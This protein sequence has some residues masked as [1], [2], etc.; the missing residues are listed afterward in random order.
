MVS[1]ATF[2]ERGIDKTYCRCMFQ[3]TCV[4]TSQKYDEPCSGQRKLNPF[5]NKPWFLRVCSASLFENTVGKGEIARYERFL[6]F[7]VFYARSTNFL[8]FFSNL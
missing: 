5:P 4:V 6:L 7:P 8:P 3:H 1:Q 2:V